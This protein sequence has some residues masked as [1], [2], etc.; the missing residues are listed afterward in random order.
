MGIFDDADDTLDKTRENIGD[1]AESLED[2]AHEAKG[3]AK[4]RWEDYTDDDQ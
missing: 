2:K 4:A 3:E 1:H